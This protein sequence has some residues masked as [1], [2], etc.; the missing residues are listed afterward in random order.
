M[1]SLTREQSRAVDR[2][3]MEEL[4]IPGIVL[5]EN[6][7]RGIAQ[8]I[9][10]RYAP[11]CDPVAIVCGPG[12][13]GGDGFVVARVLHARGARVRV[14]ALSAPEAMSDDAAHNWRLLEQLAEHDTADRLDLAR[15]ESLDHLNAYRHADLYVDA[16]LG[17][18]LA[19][20]LR[21][22]ISG[23]VAWLNSSAS[24]VI[25]SSETPLLAAA[26]LKGIDDNLPSRTSAPSTEY[27]D[28]KDKPRALN[29]L[30]NA[31][32]SHASAP[33]RM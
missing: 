6:A 1:Q 21:E 14:L 17:T 13:N 2:V 23:L 19:S 8:V 10:E 27:C 24:P 9:L 33:G 20:A 11:A 26:S 29:S 3:A 4:R 28:G 31:I 12:N 32:K 22:P 30:I 25:C 5:M 18:G 16:L 15:F 7:A